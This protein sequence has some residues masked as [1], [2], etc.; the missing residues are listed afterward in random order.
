MGEDKQDNT[1]ISAE[2]HF[3]SLGVGIL[4][5][6]KVFSIGILEFREVW[7]CLSEL[8]LPQRLIGEL[9]LHIMVSDT[10]ADTIVVAGIM[11]IMFMYWYGPLKP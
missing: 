2:S 11:A 9:V 3:R 6:C 4:C 5:I 8:V 7:P 10:L 1:C